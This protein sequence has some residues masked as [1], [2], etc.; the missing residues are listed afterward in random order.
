ML[1]QLLI[2]GYPMNN[3]H[4]SSPIIVWNAQ[5]VAGRGFLYILRELL[6]RYSPSILVLIETKISGNIADNFCRKV[7][8]DG[9]YRVDSVGFS[10]G[11]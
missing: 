1:T 8:F 7:D 6:R 4:I 11:I 2:I 10:G 9:Q 5:G 3:K